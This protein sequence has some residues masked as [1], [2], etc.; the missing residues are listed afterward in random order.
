MHKKYPVRLSALERT[1]LTALISAGTVSARKLHHA[2]LLL[3]ADEGPEGPA[4]TDQRIA[5]AID[6]SQPT[7]SRV[8]KQYVEEGLEAALNRRMPRRTPQRKLSGAHEAHLVALACSAPPTGKA[9]W[10]LRLL[11]D[12]LVE[13]EI[14]DAVSYR[15]VGRVL[16]KTNSSPG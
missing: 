3:K 11:A 13:W 8:R 9:R 15:T 16:K 6:V 2:R 12:K 14:I 1:Q 5:D 4:W 10:S 7:I